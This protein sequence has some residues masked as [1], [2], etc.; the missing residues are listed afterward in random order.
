MEASAVLK[1][2]ED[3]LYNRF[4]IID[5]IVSDN[6]STMRAMLKHPSVGVRGQVLNSSK[7][8]LDEEILQP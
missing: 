4:F 7:G 3:A 5:V 1:M 8:K 2:V 6:E